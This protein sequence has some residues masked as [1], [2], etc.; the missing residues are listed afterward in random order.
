MLHTF[1]LGSHS[2]RPLEVA[3]MRI[4]CCSS[5][6]VED[7]QPD[8]DPR[9]KDLVVLGRFLGVWSSMRKV[10]DQGPTWWNRKQSGSNWTWANT[11]ASALQRHSRSEP[12]TPNSPCRT[13]PALVIDFPYD[14]LLV[15]NLYRATSYRIIE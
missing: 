13:L 6:E 11:D 5:A 7:S 8:T 4:M 3:I 9:C 14:N 10:I 2:R 1:G 15:A 12:P